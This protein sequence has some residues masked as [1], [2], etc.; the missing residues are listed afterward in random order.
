VGP[1]SRHRTRENDA[2][3]ADNL[4]L[5]TNYV[6]IRLFALNQWRIKY[7]LTFTKYSVPTPVQAY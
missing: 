6:D 3:P 5:N 1:L 7:G 4:Q 2:G